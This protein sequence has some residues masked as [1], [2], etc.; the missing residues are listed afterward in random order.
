MRTWHFDAY[1]ESDGD[2]TRM[3]ALD[4]DPVADS[5][6]DA[7]KQVVQGVEGIILGTKYVRVAGGN[8]AVRFYLRDQSAES[9]R[10][11][12]V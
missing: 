5:V 8:R 3:A 10:L 2:L 12:A 1:V 9:R 7:M 4:L 6:L 11:K